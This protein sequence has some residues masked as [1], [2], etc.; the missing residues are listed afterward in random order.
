MMV[1][2]S[3]PGRGDPVF[4]LIAVDD[5][6]ER[7]VPGLGRYLR[8]LVV[9]DAGDPRVE[10]PVEGLYDLTKVASVTDSARGSRLR[11]SAMSAAARS[12]PSSE[13]VQIKPSNSPCVAACPD[14]SASLRPSH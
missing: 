5:G 11:T 12:R 9:R 2:E 3:F 13:Q 8:P 14:T 7:P 4:D 1:S 6:G 10:L